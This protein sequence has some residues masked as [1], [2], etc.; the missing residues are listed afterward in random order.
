MSAPKHKESS[1][2]IALPDN[3]I[4]LK[5]HRKSKSDYLERPEKATTSIKIT[6]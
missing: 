5:S 2:E 4:V 6:L 3:P 1:N